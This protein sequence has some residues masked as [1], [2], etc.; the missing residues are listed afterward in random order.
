MTVSALMAGHPM[1][2][3]SDPRQTSVAIHTYLRGLIM[4]GILPPDTVLKQSELAVLLAVS[5]TPLR[6]AFRMLQEEG[7]IEADVN[8]RAKV[9]KFEPEALD[10]LYAARI[11]LECL[12]VHMTS[13]RLTPEELREGRRLLKA[14]NRAAVGEDFESWTTLHR[15]F[16]AVLIS[17]SSSFV[18]RTI[19]SFAAHSERY[20]RVYR[21]DT[22]GS[23]AD[24]HGEH[25]RLLQ[26]VIDG[27]RERAA[28]L[29]AQH[30]SITAIA[31]LSGLKPGFEP[32]A[33]MSAV[34]MITGGLSDG[35]AAEPH[36]PDLEAAV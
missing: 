13:G 28:E 18:G 17:R 24:R 35:A 2:M 3:V 19:A 6:E 10:S 29:M 15:R 20:W 34:R 26:A 25:E 12:G 5:R 11:S 30:L 22:P 1:P 36:S 9:S 21:S 31:V 32:S 14:M 27:D 7:L 4:S 16:H 23:L 8:Q 33:V